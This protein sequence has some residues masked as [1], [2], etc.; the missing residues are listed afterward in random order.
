MD[1]DSIGF[2]SLLGDGLV[3]HHCLWLL[4]GGACKQR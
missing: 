1:V 4:S 3:D 2:G